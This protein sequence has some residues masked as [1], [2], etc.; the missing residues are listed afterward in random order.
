MG[1]EFSLDFAPPQGWTPEFFEARVRDA[2]APFQTGSRISWERLRCSIVPLPAPRR[3]EILRQNI[4]TGDKPE[5]KAKIR[6]QFASIRDGRAFHLIFYNSDFLQRNT[7]QSIDLREEFF[8]VAAPPA[9]TIHRAASEAELTRFLEPLFN[10]LAQLFGR[11]G[12]DDLLD[13]EW[14]EVD[15]LWYETK[16][17]CLEKIEWEGELDPFLDAERR[18]EWKKFVRCLVPL[19]RPVRFECFSRARRPFFRFT[20]A[21]SEEAARF[22]RLAAIRPIFPEVA[23]WPSWKEGKVVFDFRAK[24]ESAPRLLHER[25]EALFGREAIIAFL[26]EPL[27]HAARRA[28]PRDC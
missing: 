19:P 5:Y 12:M 13:T 18:I 15:P 7:D 25:L 2:L 14:L 10:E 3:I 17:G 20:F 16:P 22:Y 11:K 23:R 4:G 28:I 8:S 24:K 1:R 6:F 9:S 27:S 26:R 21:H